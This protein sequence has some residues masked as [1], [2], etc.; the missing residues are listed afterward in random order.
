[1]FLSKNKISTNNRPSIV[2]E[3]GHI[4]SSIT[5]STNI[6]KSYE[7]K[8][9]SQQTTDNFLTPPQYGKTLN[10]PNINVLHVL[11]IVTPPVPLN[12]PRPAIMITLRTTTNIKNPPLT[13]I[14][15]SP[16]ESRP[17]LLVTK[18][19]GQQQAQTITVPNGR[20]LPI[21]G[22]MSTKQQ[23]IVILSS[24][25]KSCTEQTIFVRS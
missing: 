13:T 22:Q 11:P 15:L 19:N 20:C 8:R 21:N 7:T 23:R 12:T 18:T 14:N 16:T 17:L 6:I 10:V 9:T 4:N 3:N 2:I 5:Q 1:M 25:R 24:E